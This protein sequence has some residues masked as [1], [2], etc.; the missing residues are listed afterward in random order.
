M[1]HKWFPNMSENSHRYAIVRCLSDTSSE[2]ALNIGCV[3]YRKSLHFHTFVAYNTWCNGNARIP[4]SFDIQF[5]N[6][7]SSK[8]CCGRKKLKNFM[9]GSELRKTSCVYRK[10]SSFDS[11]WNM[12]FRCVNGTFRIFGSA[13]SW[14]GVTITWVSWPVGII[15]VNWRGYSLGLCNCTWKP[16]LHVDEQKFSLLFAYNTTRSPK[17]KPAPNSVDW[18]HWAKVRQMNTNDYI[19]VSEWATNLLLA[20]DSYIDFLIVPWTRTH[21][22]DPR[23][24]RTYWRRYPCHFQTERLMKKLF[25]IMENSYLSI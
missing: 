15:I 25:W 7:D 5:D 3:G 4:F 2:L 24:S 14:N 12:H 10:N 21:C 9:H 19:C 16:W 22:L 20:S 13:F 18:Y 6:Y 17:N 11:S 8:I 1:P 23:H